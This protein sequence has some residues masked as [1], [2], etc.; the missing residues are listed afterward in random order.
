[1][2]CCL[3]VDK[4]CVDVFGMCLVFLEIFLESES[5]VCRACYVQVAI[6]SLPRQY[7]LIA[8]SCVTDGGEPPSDMLN[9]KTGHPL[10]D[11]FV[12]S[13]FWYSGDYFFALVGCFRFFVASIDI[14][15]IWFHYF[16]IFFLSFG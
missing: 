11:I 9:V 12:F 8:A 14:R 15:D 16:S 4:T 5:L 1:M 7:Q 2:V 3:K 13:I 10:V 6:I